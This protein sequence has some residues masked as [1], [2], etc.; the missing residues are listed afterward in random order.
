MGDLQPGDAVWAY[1]GAGQAFEYYRRTIP[2]KADVTLGRCDRGD[3]RNYLEQVDSQRGRSRVWV[4]AAHMSAAFRFD[5]RG[6]RG[7]RRN[8]TGIVEMVS[9]GT[10]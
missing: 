5:E 3:P 10:R 8:H 6:L 1:Y 4:L 7:G 9:E 2:L